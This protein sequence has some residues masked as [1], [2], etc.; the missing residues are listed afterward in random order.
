L[1]A[2]CTAI[3]AKCY[4]DNLTEDA[5]RKA[6]GTCWGRGEIFGERSERMRSLRKNRY[7]RKNNIKIDLQGILW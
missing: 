4:L 3:L 7:G 5:M 6:C 1:G 2:S